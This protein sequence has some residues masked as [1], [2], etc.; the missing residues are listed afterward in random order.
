MSFI[1]L[2]RGDGVAVAAEYGNERRRLGWRFCSTERNQPLGQAGAIEREANHSLPKAGVQ[3]KI[4]CVASSNIPIKKRQANW[5]A[6]LMPAKVHVLIGLFLT[7]AVAGTRAS[8][9]AEPST[10]APSPGGFSATATEWIDA[11][12]GHRIVRLSKEPGS[13]SLYFHQNPYTPQ[14]DKLIIYTPQ[15]L[16]AVNLKTRAVELVAP[17]VRYGAGSSS[18]IEVGRRRARSTTRKRRTARPSSTPPTWTARPRASFPN[19]VSPA[20]SAA[21]MRMKP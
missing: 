4:K 14:G 7:F 9:A 8:A 19:W 2:F 1:S 5:I 15:G 3:A 18:S 10:K 12:T 6:L 21:S 20:S 13:L 16:A 17:G 11:A